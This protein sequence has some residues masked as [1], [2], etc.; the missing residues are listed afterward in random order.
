MKRQSSYAKD[1]GK[2]YLVPTPIGNLEDITIRA[3]KVLT[4][5]DYVA[6]ED[7]RTSGIL[8]EKI[9]V[10]NHMISFHNLHNQIASLS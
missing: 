10:H 9:G 4:N 1:E 8:L 5:A 6:A 3:K 7:T 2:L